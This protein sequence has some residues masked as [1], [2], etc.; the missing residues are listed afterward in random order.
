MRRVASHS[1]QAYNLI[2]YITMSDEV[3]DPADL[4]GAVPPSSSEPWLKN[5][6]AETLALYA[7]HAL[8]IDDDVAPPLHTTTTFHYSADPASLTAITERK[9]FPCQPESHVYSRISNPNLTRLEAVLSSLL[10][11]PSLSY[12]SGLS[13]AF[14]IYAQARPPRVFITGGYHGVHGVLEQL[15]RIAGGTAYVRHPLADAE[16]LAGPGDVVHVETPLNPTGEALDLGYWVRVAHG[17]GALVVADATFAPPPLQDPLALGVD[18]VMHS[19]TKYIGGH[20]DL[21]LGVAATRREGWIPNMLSDRL[22]SGAVPGNM[23]AWL[24]TRS[25]RTLAVRVQRQSQTATELVTRLWRDL[26][27]ARGVGS[28]GEEVKAEDTAVAQRSHALAKVLVEVKHSSVQFRTMGEDD[29]QAQPP[30]WFAAQMPAGLHAPVFSVVCASKVLARR[31]PSKLRLF[32]H[33]TSLGGV[34]SLIEWRAMSDNK[35]DQRLMRLSI[36]MEHVDDLYEDLGRAA[37]ALVEE[38]ERAQTNGA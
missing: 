24:A 8:R 34:E 7:D 37:I 25:L 35:V 3:A 11:A 36:G 29:A 20:S 6:H 21:L 2:H 18:V 1:L 22:H 10:G 9:S 30:A 15:H 33:A 23:E 38:D 28:M 32:S 13:A 12:A 19:G 27:S 31:L 5:L 17:R 16:V 14:G 4:P 26:E